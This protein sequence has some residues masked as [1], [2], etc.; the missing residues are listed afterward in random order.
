MVQPIPTQDEI[1]EDV[2]NQEEDL[3]E[4]RVVSPQD[5][6][7]QDVDDTTPSEAEKLSN[8]GEEILDSER[9]RHQTHDQFEE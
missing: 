5:E 4:E 3:E 6:S 1:I 8:E 2:E 7:D 9:K